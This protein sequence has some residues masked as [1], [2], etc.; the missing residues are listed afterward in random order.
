MTNKDRGRGILR[1]VELLSRILTAGKLYFA[2]FFSNVLLFIFCVFFSFNKICVVP[3]SL[4]LSLYIYIYIYICVCVCVCARNSL[5]KDDNIYA[6][7]MGVE[8]SG[9][10]FYGCRSHNA[11]PFERIQH[12]S[13]R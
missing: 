9:E 2:I 6:S 1:L 13:I 8:H 12:S 11:K 3:Y 10:G 5:S 4:S 7:P